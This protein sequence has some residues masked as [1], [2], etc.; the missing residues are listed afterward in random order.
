MERVNDGSC[1]VALL[2]K[3]LTKLDLQEYLGNC[4]VKTEQFYQL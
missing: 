3:H 1:F 2:K 4:F